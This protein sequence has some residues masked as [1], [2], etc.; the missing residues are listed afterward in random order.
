M[1]AH[2]KISQNETWRFLIWREFLRFVFFLS[3]R[4]HVACKE[5]QK[6]PNVAILKFL[7]T[8]HMRG[9]RGGGRTDPKIHHRVNDGMMS[10]TYFSLTLAGNR[11]GQSKA[12]LCFG[13]FCAEVTII[14]SHFVCYMNDFV[15][16]AMLFLKCDG[17]SFVD[18]VALCSCFWFTGS[19][20]LGEIFVKEIALLWGR[21]NCEWCYGCLIMSLRWGMGWGGGKCFDL[22]V[23]CKNGAFSISIYR[24][25]DSLIIRYS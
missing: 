17:W 13:M 18:F 14:H 8:K 3:W 1:I 6:F 22:K 15:S 11:R 5:G 2:G 20:K 12:S 24:L 10:L 4:H 25:G 16:R 21:K 23:K 19:N 7:V 9:W